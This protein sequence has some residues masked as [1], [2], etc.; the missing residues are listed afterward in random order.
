MYNTFILSYDPIS[1][2]YTMN[3]LH[4]FVKAHGY[5]YQYYSPQVGTYII[6]AAASIGQMAETYRGFFDGSQFFLAQIF[7]NLTG[8]ALPQ[9]MWTWL[10]ADNPP[11]LVTY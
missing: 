1:V 9:E 2:K 11:P 10:N 5:T 7:P 3:Q 4:A 6:K 8:G